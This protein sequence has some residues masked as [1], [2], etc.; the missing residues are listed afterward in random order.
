M[1]SIL[2]KSKINYYKWTLNDTVDEKCDYIDFLNSGIRP[3][4]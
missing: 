3:R 1:N 2:K 4:I